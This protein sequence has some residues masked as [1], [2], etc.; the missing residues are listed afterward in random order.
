MSAIKREAV[1]VYEQLRVVEMKRNELLIE[2]QERGTPGQV[3]FSLGL[4]TLSHNK[5]RYIS[6]NHNSNTS[7]H[8]IQERERLLT[9]VKEDNKEIATMERQAAETQDHI[10]R[11]QEE[12]SQLDRYSKLSLN[13]FRQLKLIFLSNG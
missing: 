9:Q 11:L 8:P 10:S 7:F 12:L 3:I 6:C 1:T 2:E 4:N 13:T 5:M